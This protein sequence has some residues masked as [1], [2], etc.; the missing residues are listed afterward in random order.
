MPDNDKVPWDPDYYPRVELDLLNKRC[1]EY[2][3]DLRRLRDA[4]RSLSE[5]LKAALQ[6]V[7]RLRGQA[8]VQDEID[9]EF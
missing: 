1:D 8:P 3:C 9:D 6:Q 7:E 2:E 5:A 4:N